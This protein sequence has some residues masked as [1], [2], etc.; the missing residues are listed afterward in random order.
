M[1]DGADQA[2]NYFSTKT[3]NTGKALARPMLERETQQINNVRKE[4][5]E[6]ITEAADP[7][8]CFRQFYRVQFENIG[9]VDKFLEKI[10]LTK[11][12]FDKVGNLV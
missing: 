11:T 6:Q 10:S 5:K 4:K 9:K 12:A 8:E 3:S 1:L 2:K 7:R